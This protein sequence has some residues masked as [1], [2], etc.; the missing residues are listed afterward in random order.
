VLKKKACEP[1]SPL[2]FDHPLNTSPSISTSPTKP[3][4]SYQPAKWKVWLGALALLTPWCL[5]LFQLSFTWKTNEQY[6]HGYLVPLLCLFLLL[7]IYPKDNEIDSPDHQ[8]VLQG[9]LWLI[10]GIPLLFAFVPIWLVRGANSD[11]RLINFALFGVVFLLSLVHWYD[12]G[13]WRR[14]KHLLFPLLFFLVAIPWPLK[15]DLELTQWLQERVSSIIVDILLLMEHEARLEGTVIDVGVFGKIGVDQ[16]CSG[17]NGLQASLVVTLFLGAYYRFGWIHRIVLVLAGTLVA[18]AFNLSRA[19][20]LSFLKIKGKGH[21]LDDPLFSFVGW[22]APSVHDLA[23]WIETILIFLTI[24]LLARMAKGG[25]FLSTLANEPNRWLNLRSAP[26]PIFG[27]LSIILVGGSALFAEAHYRSTETKLT[28][29]PSLQINL[30]DTNILTFTQDISRQVAAQLHYEE[31]SSVQWQDRFRTILNHYG[32]H[33]INPNDEYWQAFE[34]RWDSGGA[35][36]AV[37][38]THS[39]ESCLPLTGLTQVSPPVGEDP[40]LI[41][42][43]VDGQDVLFE[44]YEFSRNYRKLFVFRCFWPKKS[45]SE[46]A[47]MFPRGGYSFEGRIS[48]ALEGRRNV[49]GTMLALALANVDSPRTAI[50][51]LQALANQRLTFGNRE[52]E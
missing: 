9:K 27:T 41:P 26:N 10:L 5:L 22:S 1:F 20:S 2:N 25:L 45:P 13:G 39:P 14:I 23:G 31:A 29:L 42:V 44:A 12:D 48:S 19:F 50:N 38:S 16:A 24:L 30:S 21:Y 35:C 47:N 36:T 28:E 6:A 3:N 15:R 46:Q 51:K 11:W 49:G 32:Q 34:A 17:I 52:T 18:L 8:T 33:M 40:L 43:K 4:F 7:K 37:L